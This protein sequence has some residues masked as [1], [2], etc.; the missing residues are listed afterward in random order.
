[1]VAAAKRMRLDRATLYNIRY[2]PG[3]VTLPAEA[4]SNPQL[5]SIYLRLPTGMNRFKKFYVGAKDFWRG[6]LARLKF[7][8]PGLE[9]RVETVA[10]PKINEPFYM[11]LE[12]HSTQKETL[13][14]LKTKPFPKPLQ[15]LPIGI[16]R[17]Q[18]RGTKLTFPPKEGEKITLNG[19]Q[20]EIPDED[21]KDA[22]VRFW[23]PSRL[24]REMGCQFLTTVGKMPKT[25]NIK[26][27]EFSR[28]ILEHCPSAQIVPVPQL[29]ADAS[30]P[31]TTS[32]PEIL[33]SRKV[34]V[35]I[36]GLRHH[37]IWN[38]VRQT[39]NLPYI[40][41]E[42]S[43]EELQEIRQHRKQVKKSNKDKGRVKAGLDKKKGEEQALKDA[44]A[45]AERMTAEAA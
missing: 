21:D 19:R 10:K 27:V 3:A 33:Y 40:E 26:P 39:G 9:V 41:A 14:E 22:K 45:E 31:Q 15:R 17:G 18:A 28:M 4:G 43:G 1:M 13:K 2:L 25:E 32:P 20:T 42:A 11:T 30:A 29:P 23:N 8:N 5:K 34:T 36:T 16:W 37:E 24:W 6:E 44:R 7:R 38:W 12:Y 35:P